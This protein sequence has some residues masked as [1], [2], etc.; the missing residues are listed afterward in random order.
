M[1]FFEVLALLLSSTLLSTIIVSIK[2]VFI[3]KKNRQNEVED[4][5]DNRDDQLSKYLAHQKSTDEKLEKLM[6][7]V[8]DYIKDHG[9]ISH[10]IIKSNKLILQDRIRHIALKCI[11]EEEI[12]YEV[13]KLLHDM[14]YEY[15]N[16]WK[17]NGDLNI[18]MGLVDELPLKI[19]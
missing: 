10:N 12:S 17:G 18:I 2:E 16:A 4:R 13:R 9:E 7:E 1:G 19:D 5:E 15:H 6:E 8:H 14:W 3:F 11:A